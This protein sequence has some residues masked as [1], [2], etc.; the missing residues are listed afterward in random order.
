ME[1]LIENT[2]ARV[3]SPSVTES[4]RSMPAAPFLKSPSRLCK[5][6]MSSCL[7]RSTRA[8][9]LIG[10]SAKHRDL[11]AGPA[12]KH[13]GKHDN[14]RKYACR[15]IPCTPNCRPWADYRG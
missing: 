3:P 7:A 5:D 10:R 11:H 14:K 9:T 4:L 6:L 13:S 12:I 8:F 1:V 2:N 15:F